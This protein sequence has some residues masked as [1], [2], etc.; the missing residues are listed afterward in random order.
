MTEEEKEKLETMKLEHAAKLAKEGG[1][2][3]NVE[4]S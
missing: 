1:E 3:I 4:A 2:A